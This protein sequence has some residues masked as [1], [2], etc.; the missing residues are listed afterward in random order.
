M[1]NEYALAFNDEPAEECPYKASVFV[2]TSHDWGVKRRAL[3]KENMDAYLL[4]LFLVEK[5]D[6]NNSLICSIPELQEELSGKENK[7]VFALDLLKGFGFI[8]FEKKGND[9]SI[10]VNP[11]VAYKG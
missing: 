6:R 8:S 3:I 11:G 5:M 10:R 7:V 2:N 4:L 9:Y 1:E